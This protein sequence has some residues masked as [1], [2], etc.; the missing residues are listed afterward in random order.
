[1]ASGEDTNFVPQILTLPKG[2]IVIHE[3]STLFP[4]GRV[5]PYFVYNW[6]AGTPFWSGS[7][8]ASGPPKNQD[9]VARY[10]YEVKEDVPNFIEW[11]VET[12]TALA[13]MFKRMW[14]GYILESDD[15]VNDYAMA[16]FAIQVLGYSGLLQ[17]K[18]GEVEG[19]IMGGP[20][21]DHLDF[22]KLYTFNHPQPHSGYTS[23]STPVG[24][25]FS[26]SM[27]GISF[28]TPEDVAAIRAY[29]VDNPYTPPQDE[30]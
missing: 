2:K 6:Y 17:M 24:A 1:M 28:Y 11:T 14:P 27:E 13:H 26:P 25:G 9:P 19:L 20:G 7:E 3:R 5:H 29:I 22:L 30:T 15:E 23:A 4:E 21:I 12:E 18:E 10:V 8:T 16:A